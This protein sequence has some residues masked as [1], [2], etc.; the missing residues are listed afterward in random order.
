MKKLI[1]IVL[2]LLLVCSVGVTAFAKGADDGTIQIASKNGEKFFGTELAENFVKYVA[3]N[4]DGSVWY[5]LSGDKDMDICDLVA[6]SNGSVD[7]DQS[8]TFD[9]ADGAALRALLIGKN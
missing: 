6:M 1:A 9:S 2:S 8:G 4:G 3:A 5:D 7:L